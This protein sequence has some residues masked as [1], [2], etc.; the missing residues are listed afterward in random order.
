MSDPSVDARHARTA[1]EPP[2]A[3][4]D[5]RRLDAVVRPEEPQPEGWYA[6]ALSEDVGPDRPYGCDFLG[7][8]IVVYRRA[9]AEPVVLT[10]TCPHM[11]ADLALG[12][13]VDDEVRCAYHHFRFA[14]DG[15]CASIPS[16]GR[17]PPGAR[18]H[19]Y[20]ASERFGLVW[21]YNGER[22]RFGPPE[23]RD[24][25]ED[26]LEFHA[27]RTNVFEIAPWLSIGNTFDFMH[28]RYVHGFEFDFDPR[29][30]RYLDDHRIELD[31][32]F[33]SPATGRFQQRIRVSGTNVVSFSTVADTTTVG[34]FTST[35]I[36]RTC[37]TY[38]VACVP[39]SEV[40][41]AEERRK[42]IAEQEALGDGLLADDART[43]QGIRFRAGALVAEDQAMAR[44]MEW[45]A[46]FP[47]ADPAAAY[48]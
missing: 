37:Q 15:A 33:D 24:Y 6:V 47:R 20:P 5:W 43:L 27:R 30:I 23:V 35:P 42:Q 21:A 28:L 18:V 31:L 26:D 34:L 11:G 48:R 36:G 32:D 40:A 12:D 25:S 41:S 29:E 44:Y 9:S 46:R 14:A 8:R 7:G 10:A 38:Y 4:I 19:A 17:I 16:Q 45:V 39:K 22:P 2:G 13:V 3:P 1:A